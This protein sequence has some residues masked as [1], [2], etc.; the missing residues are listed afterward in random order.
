MNTLVF[1]I[2]TVPDTDG[3]RRLLGLG[4]EL[5]NGEVAELMFQRRRQ[6]TGGSDFLRHHLHRV[7]AISVVLRDGADTLK[8]RSLGEPGDDEATLIDQFFRGIDH[9]HPTLVSWN[10]GGF[11]LP[12]LHYRGLLHGI[13]APS[14]WDTGDQYSEHRFNN[15]L[16]RFH[17]R[18]TDLMDALA[19]Y[20]P[21]ANVPL[22]EMAT[23]MGFPGKTG[24]DGSKVWPAFQQ[25]DVEGIRAYCETDVLNTWLVYLG[26][27]HFTGQLDG[28]MLAQEQERLATLLAEDGRPHL[29]EFLDAWRGER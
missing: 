7:V 21:R 12:V 15:Y 17:W 25:G 3:A 19:G 14:Y 1:D 22:D 28:P 11:D 29:R 23:L 5:T 4:D 10:G 9:Y 2:E 27:Q 8:V 20:Q 24:M 6:A 16:G 13:Q 18:H 26:F